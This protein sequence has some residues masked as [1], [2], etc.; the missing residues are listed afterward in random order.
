[1]HQ[2]RGRKALRWPAPDDVPHDELHVYTDGAAS[3]KHG[4]WKAGCGVWF[5]VDSPHNMSTRPRGKQTVN[6]AELT[7]VILSVRKALGML[8][9]QQKLVVHSDPTASIALTA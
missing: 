4:Q 1:M 5:G 9:H 2:L 7:A 8:A 6:R 3:K